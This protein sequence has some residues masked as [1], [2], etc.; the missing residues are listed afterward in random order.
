LGDFYRRG[1]GVSQDYA[2]AVNWYRKAAAQGIAAAQN[3]LGVC[4]EKG[5][6]VPKNQA[7]ADKWFRKA[8]EQQS[9]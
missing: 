5:L 9:L 8:A 6:G 3:N 4:Y 1:E 7:E 2:E